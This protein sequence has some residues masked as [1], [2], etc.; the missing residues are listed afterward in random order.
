[1]IPA[2]DHNHVLPPYV[3]NP[4]DHRI[5]LLMSAVL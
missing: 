3:G 1:M 5:S 2:F 4:H